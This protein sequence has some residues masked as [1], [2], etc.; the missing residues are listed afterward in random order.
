MTMN[1]RSGYL[2]IVG[3]PNV[4]KSTLLNTLIGRKI[5][6]TSPKP[7]TTRHQILGI[8]TEGDIQAIYIDTP[9]LHPVE[10]RVMSRYLNK[11]ATS[12]ILDA[13]VIVFV[14]DARKWTEQEDKILA[15]IQEATAPVVLVMNKIDLLSDRAEV[16]PLIEKV[17]E[18]YDFAHIVPMSAKR[19]DD[20]RALEKIVMRMLPEGPHYFPEDQMTD[21]NERFQIAEIVREKLILSTNQELPYS[22]TVV[23][24]SIKDTN[25]LVD[26]SVMIWV[27]REGQKAI[28][29]GKNGTQLKKIGTAARQ[30][31]AV[32]LGRKVFLRLWVKVKSDWT[33]DEQA[34]GHLGY[35]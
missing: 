13:N 16:L 21:K 3:R 22:T 25:T 26:I 35:E 15:C 23:V 14:I 4:G 33:N 11:L 19:V 1:T 17:S 7:Q 18:K 27:E 34:M 6:I 29:I 24:E 28:V 12:V 2:A 9:G 8:K 20:V 31:I 5:S 30:D 10:K 32:L